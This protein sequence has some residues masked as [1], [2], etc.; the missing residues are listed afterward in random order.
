MSGAIRDSGLRGHSARFRHIPLTPVDDWT[1][2]DIPFTGASDGDRT[3]AQDDS[4]EQGAQPIDRRRSGS[5][6]RQRDAQ[7]QS[8]ERAGA[9]AGT[10]AGQLSDSV[11][12]D[13][14]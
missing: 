3:D 9:R 6:S 11:E 2:V 8:V 7:F 1:V 4:G 13:F 5:G 14:P 12:E 10:L